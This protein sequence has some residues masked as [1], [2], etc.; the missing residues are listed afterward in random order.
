[1]QRKVAV[2]P[3]CDRSR[4]YGEPFA[5]ERPSRVRE[6]PRAV[7]GDDGEPPVVIRGGDPS[8]HLAGSECRMAQDEVGG[9]HGGAVAGQPQGWRVM[10]ELVGDIRTQS[11]YVT[12]PNPLTPEIELVAAG[13]EHHALLQGWMDEPRVSRWWGAVGDVRAYL[14]DLLG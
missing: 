10:D 12:I 5:G 2:V 8:P 9:E 1:M 13:E 6:Q 3:T 14:A 4:G 11:V 7:V